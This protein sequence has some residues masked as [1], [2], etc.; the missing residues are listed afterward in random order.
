MESLDKIMELIFH[1]IVIGVATWLFMLKFMINYHKDLEVKPY[2][3]K[4]VVESTLIV[5]MISL[6]VIID[7]L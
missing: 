1:P 5:I 6:F 4:A 2:L 7:K 3:H